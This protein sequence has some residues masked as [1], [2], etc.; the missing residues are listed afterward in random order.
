[1]KSNKLAEHNKLL[2]ITLAYYHIPP[3]LK[4]KKQTNVSHFCVKKI[5]LKN[6]IYGTQKIAET[7]PS[8]FSD[9]FGTVKNTKISFISRPN[10]TY[11][12][13]RF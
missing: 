7:F 12:F 5:N 13:A 1:M 2:P 9:N 6:K 10:D 3:F 11:T 8:P 4:K